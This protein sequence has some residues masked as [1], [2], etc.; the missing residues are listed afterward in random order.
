MRF[1]DQKEF[2]IFSTDDSCDELSIL[3]SSIISKDF[4]SLT[5]GEVVKLDVES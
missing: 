3:Q 2:H 5:I 1:S 4:Q